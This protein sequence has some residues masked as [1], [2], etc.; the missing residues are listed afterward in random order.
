M[1]TMLIKSHFLAVRIMKN[2]VKKNP[3][4]TSVEI[5]GELQDSMDSVLSTSTIRRCLSNSGIRACTAK[6]MHLLTSSM[7]RK[8]D[9]PGA[10]I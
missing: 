8:K 9:K 7:A 1:A 6:R 5:H 2:L 3:K 10:K 4:L